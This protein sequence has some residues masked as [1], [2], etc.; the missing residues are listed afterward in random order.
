MPYFQ[1]DVDKL[2]KKIKGEEKVKMIFCEW[3]WCMYNDIKEGDKRGVCQCIKDVILESV[4]SFLAGIPARK[5]MN[6]LSLT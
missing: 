3:T 2:I 6:G 1:A 5:R 4:I